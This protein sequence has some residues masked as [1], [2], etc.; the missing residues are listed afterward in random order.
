MDHVLK[1]T[2]LSQAAVQRFLSDVVADKKLTRVTHSHF[3]LRYMCWTFSK[4][5]TANARCDAFSVPR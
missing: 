1:R 2:Y 5:E 4:V 3:G